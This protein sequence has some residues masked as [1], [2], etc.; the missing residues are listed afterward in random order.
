L[1]ADLEHQV[2]GVCA[3]RAEAARSLLR[4]RDQQVADL[5][6]GAMIDYSPAVAPAASTEEI[7]NI[8]AHAASKNAEPGIRG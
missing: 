1:A 7:R 4:L 2:R 5:D 3:V 8:L 6:D